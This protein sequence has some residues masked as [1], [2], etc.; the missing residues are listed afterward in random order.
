MTREIGDILIQKVLNHD[1]YEVERQIKLIEKIEKLVMASLNI[2]AKISEIKADQIAKKEATKQE[3]IE[4]AKQRLESGETVREVSQD[5]PERI[6]REASKDIHSEPPANNVHEDVHKT[7]LPTRATKA[8]A[9]KAE[10]TKAE[11][12]EEEE[13]PILEVAAYNV[14]DERA[15]AMKRLAGLTGLKRAAM[16]AAIDRY[17]KDREAFSEAY[18]DD[19]SMKFAYTL[20]DYINGARFR[21]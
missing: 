2:A 12:A 16:A 18:K 21:T 10:A 19:P 7:E 15:V 3:Q 11:D 13:K 9:T 5:I 20:D 14:D 6:V 17:F 1:D 8:E 4:E